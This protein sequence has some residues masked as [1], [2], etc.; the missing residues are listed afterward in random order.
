MICVEEVW[1]HIGVLIN[2]VARKY[3][4]AMLKLVKKL[5]QGPDEESSVSDADA[6][7]D[8]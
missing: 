2:P 5:M 4:D 8:E 1:V 7:L 3:E 6:D